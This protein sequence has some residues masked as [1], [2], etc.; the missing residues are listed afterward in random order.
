MEQRKAAKVLAVVIVIVVIFASALAVWFSITNHEEKSQYTI[1]KPIEIYSYDQFT[2]ENGVSRG[3]GTASDPYVIEGLEIEPGENGY[4]L[5]IS[6]TN[7]PVVIRDMSFHYDQ[8]LPAP[9][10]GGPQPAGI[11][12]GDVSNCVIEH[13]RFVHLY[14]G[15]SAGEVHNLS[16][17]SNNIIGCTIGVETNPRPEHPESLWSSDVVFGDNTITDGWFGLSCEGADR[18]QISGN[19]LQNNTVG[20][21]IMYVDHLR[22]DNNTVTD[23]GP[24]GLKILQSS[25]VIISGNDLKEI[26][27]TGI[28]LQGIEGANISFSN[29]TSAET[30][31]RVY[32]C[33]NITFYEVDIIK[34]SGWVSSFFTSGIGMWL[35]DSANVTVENVWIVYYGIGVARYGCDNFTWAHSA[36]NN[37]EIAQLTDDGT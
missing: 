29:V 5:I 28:E 27:H 21:E 11:L 13:C 9:G 3:A 36:I 1:H 2:P 19:Y 26:E 31:V 24:V 32:R 23:A 37:Y 6:G 10:Y 25:Q 16:V 30:G 15:I 18:M 14:T 20:A 22:I 8:A 4:G 17:Y 12:L 33:D 7:T 34:D 35:A